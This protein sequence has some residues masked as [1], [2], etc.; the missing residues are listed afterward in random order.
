MQLMGILNFRG[1]ETLQ[2]INNAIRSNLEILRSIAASNQK[3]TAALTELA[4]QD[5]RD[6]KKIKDLSFI[7]VL[8]VPATLVAVCAK[9]AKLIPLN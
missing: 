4:Q 5:Q 3:E 1:N 6:S 9:N 7:V 8:Y 2:E